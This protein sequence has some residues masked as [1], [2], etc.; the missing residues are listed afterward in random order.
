MTFS[1][2]PWYQPETPI[3]SPT[4]KLEGWYQ[5]RYGIFHVIIYLS[6]I[7]HIAPLASSNSSYIDFFQALTFILQK[8]S[9]T[10][11]IC[12][13]TL[14]IPIQHDIYIWENYSVSSYLNFIPIF[15]NV[16]IWF[17]A[18]LYAS[19]FIVLWH[20]II[21][22]TVQIPEVEFGGKYGYMRTNTDIWGQIQIFE[23]KY[24]YLPWGQIT[25]I[26]F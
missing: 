22:T 9:Q 17:N 18:Y 20:I 26:D 19:P 24:G 4:V 3:S 10:M 15:W 16:L 14:E 25:N 5:G 11:L 1:I 6:H 2:S 7:L 21:E 8:R 12:T 13:M 23:G